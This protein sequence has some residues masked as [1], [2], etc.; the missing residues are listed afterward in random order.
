M[1]DLDFRLTR[2]LTGVQ[3]AHVCNQCQD[4]ELGH[5]DLGSPSW[6]V[7]PVSACSCSLCVHVWLQL[8]KEVMAVLEAVAATSK[9]SSPS[10]KLL[11]SVWQHAAQRTAGCN[12]SMSA[13]PAALQ[14]PHLPAS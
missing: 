6:H 13:D 11:S 2:T 3:P 8:Y 5:I 7:V 14:V 12:C 10:A 9:L 4:M 1:R